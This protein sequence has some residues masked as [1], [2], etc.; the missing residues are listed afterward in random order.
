MERLSKG[1][2]QA[3]AYRVKTERIIARLAEL[4]DLGF[5]Q[6]LFIFREA[7][8]GYQTILKLKGPV[9]VTD[10]MVGVSQQGRVKVWVSE[11]FGRSS[12]EPKEHRQL[13]ETAM[14]D[15]IYRL[16]SKHLKNGSFPQVF[17]QTYEQSITRNFQAAL[18]LIS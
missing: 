4:K 9:N 7:L 15:T 8:K 12:P 14:V 3:V 6:G 5:E 16:V 18:Q 2:Q 17:R 10:R 1:Q 11:N 13:T